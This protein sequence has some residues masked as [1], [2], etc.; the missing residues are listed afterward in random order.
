MPGGRLRRSKRFKVAAALTFLEPLYRASLILTDS[1]VRYLR[2][3]AATTCA[4][5]ATE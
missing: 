2:T 5:A 4:Y 3:S 1:K